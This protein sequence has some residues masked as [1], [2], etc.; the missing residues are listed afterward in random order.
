MS[1]LSAEGNVGQYVKFQ[2]AKDAL[3]FPDDVDDEELTTLVKDANQDIEI[4]LTPYAATLPLADGTPNFKAAGRAGLI[5]VNARWKEKKHNFEL[6]IT[7]DKRY[8]QKMKDLQQALKTE[9][10]IRTQSLIVSDDPRDKKLPLPSQYANF[11]FD[12]FA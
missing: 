7:L 4:K 8:E 11:V 5:Y 2:E 3:D 9:P 10:T 12:D 6:A 1:S